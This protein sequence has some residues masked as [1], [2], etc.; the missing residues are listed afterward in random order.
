MLVH[1]AISLEFIYDNP[2][3]KAESRYII[4]HVRPGRSNAERR[5]Q[6]AKTANAKTKHVTTVSA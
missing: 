2:Q 4:G 6:N 1:N 3:K 5:S